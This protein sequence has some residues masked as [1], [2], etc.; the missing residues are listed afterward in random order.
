MDGVY[1]NSHEG[2]NFMWGSALDKLG[3]PSAVAVEAAK[4][5]HKSAYERDVNRGEKNKYQKVDPDNEP[6]HNKAIKVGYKLFK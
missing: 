2:L 1:Y 5:Y 3:V 4:K 6:N